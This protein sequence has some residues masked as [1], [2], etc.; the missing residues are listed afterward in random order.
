MSIQIN[1]NEDKD[2]KLDDNEKV[3]KGIYVKNYLLNLQSR[4]L[5]LYYI[6]VS[7]D[8]NTLLQE[9]NTSMWQIL[10]YLI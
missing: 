9:V 6:D 8:Q 5:W 3:S 2:E 10:D 7:Q 1:T 4:L